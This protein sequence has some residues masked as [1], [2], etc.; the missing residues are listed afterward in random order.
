MVD[1]VVYNRKEAGVVKRAEKLG[2]ASFYFPKSRMEGNELLDFLTERGIDYIILAG[3]LLKI[4]KNLIN[5]FPDRILN[6]HPSLLPKYGGKGMYGARVHEAV[7]ENGE[8]ESGITI[9]LVNEIYDDGR[10]L[11]QESV[12]LDPEDS[13]DDIARKI[14][15]LEYAYFPQTI[16]EYCISNHG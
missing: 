11:R 6:I 3:Y 4:P 14:H 1:S 12:K 16:A 10:I 13:P 2:I 7:K 15:A 5:A 9:H 8:H